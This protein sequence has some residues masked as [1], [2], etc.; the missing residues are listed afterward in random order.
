MHSASH[1]AAASSSVESAT[2]VPRCS[3][4]APLCPNREIGALRMHHPVRVPSRLPSPRLEPLNSRAD[5]RQENA[6]PSSQQKHAPRPARSVAL[7]AAVGAQL[8]PRLVCTCSRCRSAPVTETQLRVSAH[9]TGAKSRLSRINSGARFDTR[10]ACNPRQRDLIGELLA[11]A[12]Q[13]TL[14]RP[15]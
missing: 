14:Q 3:S 7:V 6:T 10:D 12:G 5:R 2:T 8:H 15:G 13:C 1:C 9:A 11:P 4:S